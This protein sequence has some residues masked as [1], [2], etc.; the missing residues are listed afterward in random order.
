[1]K[2]LLN[3][4]FQARIFLGCL[5]VAMV[6]LTLS[7]LVTVF[8]FSTSVT[9]Q[10]SAEGEGQMAEINGRLTRLLDG[11]QLACENLTKDG[12]AAWVMIDNT[13]VQIQRDLYLGLYQAVQ[14]IYSHARFCIYDAGGKLRFTTNAESK[15]GSLPTNW[16]LLK[17]AAGRGGMTYYRTDPYLPYTDKSVL[18]QGAYSLENSHGARLGYVVLD[19]NRRDFDSLLNGFYGSGDVVVLLD[20]HLQP[21]YCSRPEYGNQEVEGFIREA[22]YGGKKEAGRGEYAQYFW[23]RE[24]KY[25]FYVLL[26]HS[27]PITAPALHIMRIISLLM[28]V[29]GLFLCMAISGV[30]TRSVSWPVSQLDRAMAKVKK[31]DLS[32]RVTYNRGDELGRLGESFNRMSADLQKYVED[33]VQK[34]KDLDETTLKLY[35]TQ[36][37]PHFIYNTLDTIKWN[38]KIGQMPEIAILAENLAAILRRSISSQPFIRLKKELETIGCYIRIQK[39]RFTGRFLFETEIPDQLEACLIPKMILQPLVENAILH[40][41]DGCE[42]GYICIYASQKGGVLRI[43]VTD[44]GC[45]MSQEMLD[46]INGGTPVRREGHLGLYNVI[47]ILK[48]YYGQEY[49]IKAAASDGGTTVTMTL[50]M[51]KEAADV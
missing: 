10:V 43:S 22:L 14:E 41:L 38:A 26:R 1:M 5:L 15:N 21:I 48:I 51:R 6:P 31:G 33:T 7:G 24:Q 25:G 9:G 16:G 28:A 18:L 30:L 11:C 46:W 44:D 40:G 4:S 45:G 32:V 37:N 34:Q 17:K 27:A 39:I 36:L 29:L 42:N 3:R 13:T 49:G 20:S 8:L 50:P 2:G 19:F 23:S 35:Q 47:Q 12:S